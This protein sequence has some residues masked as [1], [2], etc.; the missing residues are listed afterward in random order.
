MRIILSTSAAARLEAAHAFLDSLPRSS[1]VV[2]VGASRGAADDLARAV[3][4]RS[5]AT[6]GL[7]R[8]SLTQL[9]ARAAA[10]GMAGAGRAPGTTAGAEA[11]A[12]RA[13]FDAMAAGELAYFAPVAACPGFPKALARTLHELRL[14]GVPSSRLAAS[15]IAGADVGRLLARVE[16]HLASASL[17]DRA[18]L[19]HLAAGAYR[20]G[21]FRW[22]LSPVLL[23]DV[24]LDSRAERAFVAAI[25]G[26]TP[27]M[28]ATVPAGDD[29]AFEA[30]VS[31]SREKPSIEELADPAPRSADLGNLRRFVFTT[32]RPVSRAPSGDVRLFSAPGEGT[33]GRRD[34]AA[35]AGRGRARRAVRRDGGVPARA[36][37]VPRAARARV[38]ARRRAGLLRSRH[39]AS[40]SGRAARSSRCCRARSTACPRSASTSTCRSARC[41]AL[42]IP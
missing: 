17:D 4:R 28:V 30:L 24:P 11:I 38:R 3:S 26:R 25:A 5:G 14:A 37:A 42:A 23:L 1:E 40:R 13:I 7:T 34:R 41:R 12:V 16:E 31:M 8:F 10:A 21:T 35:R 9:A 27:R 33:R 18:S 22:A 6:F 2:I 36:A 39:P 29:L 20:D 19:F 32:D 15:G